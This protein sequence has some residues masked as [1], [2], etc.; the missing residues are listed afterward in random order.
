[1]DP[2]PSNLGVRQIAKAAGVSK[3][4]VSLVLRNLPGPSRATQEKV[5]RLAQQSG[6]VPDARVTTLMA[7]IRR[8]AKKTLVPIAWLDTLAEHDAWERFKYLSPYLEGARARA[9][10]LGYSVERIWARQPDMTI[11][12]V[13]KIIYQRGI[14]GIIITHQ[15]R[16]HL[17]LNWDKLASVTLE[18][19]LLAPRLHR[20]MTDY[21]FNLLLA[22]KML[23]RHGY[24]RIGICL[25]RDAGHGSYNTCL[26]AV[27]YFQASLPDREI[28]PHLVYRREV[29]DANRPEVNQAFKSWTRRHKPDVVIGHDNN[30]L[31]M[32]G[33]AG[34]CVP[35]DIGVAHIATDDDVSEWAGIHS[36]RREIGAAAVEKVISL[37]QN[38][39]FGLPTTAMNTAIRGTWHGGRTLLTPKPK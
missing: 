39:Q 21:T 28:V 2:Y 33:L 16:N 20:V 25:E 11:R 19:Q 6:Y 37:L 34:Y 14:E 3:S 30:L 36:K 1:M 15:A 12:R 7:T 38:G 22:L 17:R 18:E 10:Q 27:H 5:L 29:N 8:A 32:V 35:D 26:A 31:E 23:R 24:R 4:T 13:S 9:A